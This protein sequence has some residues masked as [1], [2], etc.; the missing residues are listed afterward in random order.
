MH[1]LVSPFN[2]YGPC[3]HIKEHIWDLGVHLFSRSDRTRPCSLYS[4]VGAAF[5]NVLAYLTPGYKRNLNELLITLSLNLSNAVTTT[6][7]TPLSL[8]ISGKKV[9]S[10]SHPAQHF[11][12]SGLREKSFILTEGSSLTHRYGKTEQK[13][14][15]FKPTCFSLVNR[16]LHS[17]GIISSTRVSS[18]ATHPIHS[19]STLD[20]KD[21]SPPDP[22]LKGA[23]AFLCC[24]ALRKSP[25]P[26]LAH[27]ETR[28]C[29]LRRLRGFKSSSRSPRLPQDCR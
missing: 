2:F 16:S 10:P 4:Y 29:R 3:F 26:R 15:V 28:D 5:F 23:Q 24:A 12:R 19:L 6:T 18:I 22:Q 27:S 17:W 14:P 11:S 25:I 21:R 13:A 8:P 7:T 20:V 1:C 9:F